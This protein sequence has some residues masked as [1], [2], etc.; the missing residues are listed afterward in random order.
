MTN[1][2]TLLIVVVVTLVCAT[3]KSQVA[4]VPRLET[5]EV[6]VQ[7]LTRE[8]TLAISDPLSVFSFVLKSLP[9]RV[10][11]YPTENYYYFRFLHQ[12]TGCAG[13][14]RLDPRDRDRGRVQFTYYRDPSEW[15][16]ITAETEVPAIEADFDRSN[17]VAVEKVEALASRVDYDGKSV[18]FARN[19]LSQV[20]LP[21]GARGSD[22]EVFGTV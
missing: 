19:D 1:W 15:M 2:K 13:N 22:E 17:N 21:P 10:K 16:N 7:D 8:S 9:E 6:Y 11:V 4:Q 3:A 12:G 14:I 5:N 18:I 20:K